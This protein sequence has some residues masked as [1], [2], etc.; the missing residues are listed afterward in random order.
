MTSIF[1]KNEF[2]AMQIICIIICNYDLNFNECNYQE[3][4]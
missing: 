3:T 1:Q 2:H 4:N